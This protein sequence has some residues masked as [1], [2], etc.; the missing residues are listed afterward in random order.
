[1]ERY[2]NHIASK[3]T[4]DEMTILGFLFEQ[5]ANALFKA[6]KKKTVLSETKLTIAKLRKAMEK[7]ESKYFLEVDSST[8]EHKLFITEF[9]E[10]ALN[11][12]L[13][14]EEF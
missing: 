4:Y 7:L 10:I 12:Q 3:L 2:F 6:I 8:K 5:D 14:E 1:M 9:G 13:Q 11:K